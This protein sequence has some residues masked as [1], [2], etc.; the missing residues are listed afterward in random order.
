MLQ[1]EVNCMPKSALS[2]KKVIQY[3]NICNQL[4]VYHLSQTKFYRVVKLDQS[5]A[6][7]RN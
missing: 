5:L 4:L 2:K 6:L 3:A 7:I 1:R